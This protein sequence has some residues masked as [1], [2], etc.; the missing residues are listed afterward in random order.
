MSLARHS[1]LATA[2]LGGLCRLPVL[3]DQAD[4][5]ALLERAATAMGGTA[6]FAKIK[7]LVVRSSIEMPAAFVTMATVSYYKAPNLIYVESDIPMLGK[8]RQ[9]YDGKTGWSNDPVQGYH[10]LTGVALEQLIASSPDHL[11][12]LPGYYAKLELMPDDKVGERPVRV[13]RGIT[14]LGAEEIFLLDAQTFL[15]L[16]LDLTIDSGSAGKLP[17]QITLENWKEIP[18]T[19]AKSPYRTVTSSSAPQMIYT[20]GS[21]EVNVPVDDTLFAPK[22]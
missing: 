6:A 13:V 2:L 18:G 11:V 8:A 19:G 10:E 20:V 21:I 12:R 15:P 9:G 7:T 14:P 22:R 5:K 4:P 1:L 3:A 16:R 17:S